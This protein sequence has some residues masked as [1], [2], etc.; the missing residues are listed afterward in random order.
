MKKLFL[1]LACSSLGI[2][3]LNAQ[4]Q[5]VKEVE[6]DLAGATDYPALR[7]KLK[8]AFEN[9]ESKNDAYTW[10]VAAKIE[11]QNYDDMYKVRIVNPAG[12]D[13]SKMGAA[14]LDGYD[15]MKKA[16]PLDS[17]PEKDKKT[18]EIKLDKKTGQP[19]I[20][21]KYSGKIV[22]IMAENY[23]ALNMIVGDLHNGKEY[24]NAVRAY[25]LCASLPFEPYMKGKMSQPA[26][27]I[28][29]ELR[30]YQGV[31]LWQDD[32]PGDAIGAFAQARKLG[33]T[34]KEAYDYPLNCAAQVRDE[35]M[36]AE[37]AK[38]ALPVYGKQDSQYVRILINAY[39]NEKNYD[40]ANKILDQ[41]INDDPQ[42]AEFVNLKGNLVENQSSIEEALPYFKQA[43]DLDPTYS[44]AYFDL[45]RYY[46]NKA[47]KVRDENVDLIGDA[48][49]AMV[50]PLYEQALPY[51][52]K[53]YELDK[54]NL[55][56]KNA[57]RSIYYQLGNEEKLNAIEN[58]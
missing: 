37:I 45:G 26:D 52:E 12:A 35:K 13:I 31:A 6:K 14:L 46:F 36:I 23:N 8:P 34:K 16:L 19:K 53:A 49:V 42:N 25:E 2:M 57:L 5:L 9:E 39:L 54:E 41:A 11:M 15:Y 20:K 17:V 27:T 7:E 28:V 44:K 33:Y 24:K 22:N 1:I 51:L 55:D 18:G 40:E 10:F 4:V 56:A 48:L 47:I 3:G 50:N 38:E 30:F 43:V 29:G 21:A 32:N 58:Q